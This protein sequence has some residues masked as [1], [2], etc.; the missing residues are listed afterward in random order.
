MHLRLSRR[1]AVVVTAAAALLCPAA[2]SA[3]RSDVK[4]MTRNVYLGA[5]LIPLATTPP[6]QFEQAAASRYQTVLRNDFPTRAKAIAAEAAAGQ[7]MAAAVVTT[8]AARRD[9]RRFM[10][11]QRSGRAPV[12]HE[13]FGPFTPLIE[14]CPR[15][16]L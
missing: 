3:A 14:V 13:G 7:R 1:A 4:I 6:D 10:A 12:P 8:T 2:A 5:D 15:L 11:R 16:T 9:R